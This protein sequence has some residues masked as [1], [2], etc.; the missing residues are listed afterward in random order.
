[1]NDYLLTNTV[2]IYLYE[3]HADDDYTLTNT[4]L[5]NFDEH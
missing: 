5:I 1:M 4:I 3:H 2:L